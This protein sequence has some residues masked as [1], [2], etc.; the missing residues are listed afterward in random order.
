MRRSCVFVVSAFAL[1]A[2]APLTVA[3]AADLELKTLPPAPAPVPP[4]IVAN[5]TGFYV[6]INGG[7]GWSDMTWTYPP[8][9]YGGFNFFDSI[10]GGSSFSTRPTGG[11]VGGQLGYNFQYGPAVFGAEFTG[12]WSGLNQ[13]LLGPADPK[14]PLDAYTTK[15]QDLETLTLRFG[16]SPPNAA[17]YQNWLVYAKAGI[18]SGQVRL[19]VISGAPYTGETYS[20]AQRL[21]GPTAGVGLEYLITPHVVV[22]LEYDYAALY[23]F[24]F[25]GNPVCVNVACS[26]FPKV[27]PISI[28]GNAFEVQSLLGRVTYKF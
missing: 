20:S 6:G 19:N 4:P 5:W 13:T 17:F 22:G 7:Y 8:L 25:D 10:P 28:S 18:A 3:S 11:L 14:Y 26:G 12:D 24:V 16:Y 9:Q 2:G 23:R 27:M 21:W 1:L 15:L